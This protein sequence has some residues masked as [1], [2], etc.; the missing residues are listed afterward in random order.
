MQLHILHKYKY[1]KYIF[2]VLASFYINYLALDILYGVESHCY[3]MQLLANV[4]N[5]IIFMS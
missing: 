4:Y 2:S 5:I 1:N 3:I